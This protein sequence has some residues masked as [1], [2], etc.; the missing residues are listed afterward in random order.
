MESLSSLKIPGKH[1]HFVLRVFALLTYKTKSM[2]TAPLLAPPPASLHHGHRRTRASIKVI[3]SNNQTVC[4]MQSS[5]YRLWRTTSSKGHHYRCILCQS[6]NSEPV[7][8]K[9]DVHGSNTNGP[10]FLQT[11]AWANPAAAFWPP[12]SFCWTQQLPVLWYTSV[13][14][15]QEITGMCFFP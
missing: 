14:R 5:W 8:F 3:F 11:A 1:L 10:E 15:L 6:F 7:F 2:A 12:H 13:Q 9:Y 4:F